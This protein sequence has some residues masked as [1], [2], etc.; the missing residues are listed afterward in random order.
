MDLNLLTA[1]APHS[2]PLSLSLLYQLGC[3]GLG[4]PARVAQGARAQ[5][6]CGGRKRESAAALRN[7][8]VNAHM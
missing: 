7:D 4:A 3:H 5:R 6:G 2:P 8:H 1:M